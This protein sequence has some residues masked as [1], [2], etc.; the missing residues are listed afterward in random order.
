M[1]NVDAYNDMLPS[2]PE[3]TVTSDASQA[4]WGRGGEGQ[5]QEVRAGGP[6]LPVES[7]FHMNYFEL[8]ATFLTL[9]SFHNLLRGKHFRLLV[10]NSTG[11]ARINHM[12]TSYSQSCSDITLAIW[13]WCVAHEV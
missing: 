6:W 9:Q 5:C 4:G 13:Q 11:V 7:Q 12:G 10:D 8:K 1:V 3:I 2:E